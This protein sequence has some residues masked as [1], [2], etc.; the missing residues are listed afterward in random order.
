MPVVR[1]EL[2]AKLDQAEAES[3]LGNGES[4]SSPTI[5]FRAN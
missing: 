5:K 4:D 2:K 3:K 1:E